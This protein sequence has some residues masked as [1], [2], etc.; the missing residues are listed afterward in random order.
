MAGNQNQNR[1][2]QLLRYLQALVAWPGAVNSLLA[3]EFYT[4]LNESLTVGLIK[5]QPRQSP[6]CSAKEMMDEYVRS[7]SL[8]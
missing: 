2:H 1:G 3:D 6:L 8:S 5:V 7:Y 4:L